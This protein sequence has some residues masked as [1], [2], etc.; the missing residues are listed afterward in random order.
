[1][2]IDLPERE[3]LRAED[4][5]LTALLHQVPQTRN[6]A[7]TRISESQIKQKS[8]HDKEI[9]RPQRFNIGDKVLYFNVI[10]D[11]SHSGKFK[12]K[13]RGPFV[14]QAV[15]PNEAYKLISADGQ[16]LHTPINGNLL[17]PYRDPFFL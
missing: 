5:R 15:L 7:K 12:P 3:N 13:W 1:M 16:L 14:I 4:D 17:K 9:K 11:H 10:L 2:P 8:R 6:Q